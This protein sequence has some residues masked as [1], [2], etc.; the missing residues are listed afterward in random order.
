MRV[1]KQSIQLDRHVR[2][3]RPRDDKA[4]QDMTEGCQLEDLTRVATD[5]VVS[6][7]NP[8]QPAA[9]GLNTSEVCW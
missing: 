7:P 9:K 5:R 6:L 8:V 2:L 4:N 1:T 3:R